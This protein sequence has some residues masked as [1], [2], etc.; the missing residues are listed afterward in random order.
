VF[1]PNARQGYTPPRETRPSPQGCS[2]VSWRSR[3]VENRRTRIHQERLRSMDPPQLACLCTTTPQN[4]SSVLHVRS[5]RWG[6][7]AS[8]EYLKTGSILRTRKECSVAGTEE[9]PDE[10]EPRNER[11]GG[12]GSRPRSRRPAVGDQLNVHPEAL[13]NWFGRPR[14]DLGVP[15]RQPR[16][17]VALRVEGQR[18]TV[19][20]AR[21]VA[22]PVWADVAGLIA[23]RW[24]LADSAE[25]ALSRVVA[26]RS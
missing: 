15:Q 16:L 23:T 3:I 2:C 18:S 6:F 5:L 13:R 24:Q 20:S 26:D 25:V 14:Q 4:C 10:H 19:L 8:P 1:A 17:C 22:T 21:R 7:P 9:Y 12:I 11:C